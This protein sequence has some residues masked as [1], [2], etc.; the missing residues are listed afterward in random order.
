MWSLLLSPLTPILT[1]VPSFM[2]TP[3]VTQV[4][5]K[6]KLNPEAS[7]TFP[8]SSNNSL[9][10]KDNRKPRLEETTARSLNSRKPSGAWS[11]PSPRSWHPDRNRPLKRSLRPSGRS[12]GRKRVCRPGRRD[13]VWFSMR[14]LRIGYPDGVQIA[15]RRLK[16]NT[17]GSWRISLS[18]LR[19]G[20]I[21][22]LRRNRR[23]RWCWKRKSLES[24]RMIYMLL[25]LSTGPRVSRVLLRYSKTREEVQISL[26]MTRLKSSK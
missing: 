6:K 24:W 18:T 10:W 14:S 22:S 23:R 2:K 21:R 20:L 3:K 13:L 7:P 12:L 25:R 16:R 8:R 19:V 4:S 15:K 26:Q 5:P 9:T 11:Y 17:S 1:W